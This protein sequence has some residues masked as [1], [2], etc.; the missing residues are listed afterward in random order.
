MS[1]KIANKK[2][3]IFAINVFFDIFS[4]SFSNSVFYNPTISACGVKFSPPSREDPH[5]L[6]YVLP[7]LSNI[8]GAMVWYETVEIKRGNGRFQSIPPFFLEPKRL[9]LLGCLCGFESHIDPFLINLFIRKC[10]IQELEHRFLGP[11]S[12]HLEF[13][14]CWRIDLHPLVLQALHP[15]V[16]LLY[17]LPSLNSNDCLG[18]IGDDLLD[19]RRQ[20]HEK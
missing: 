19:I 20:G 15:V 1:V 16:Y 3:P 11:I 18:D 4:S 6:Y 8:F 13:F 17:I 14:F 12:E 2:M 7:V 10:F 9:I 5:I